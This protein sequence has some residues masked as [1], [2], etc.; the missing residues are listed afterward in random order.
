M[1]RKILNKEMNKMNKR[2]EKF[3]TNA[4]VNREFTIQMDAIPN[5]K[6]IPGDSV[7]GHKSLEV[8]NMMISEKEIGQQNENL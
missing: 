3:L 2:E 4:P 1:K 5:N 7:D 6:N 8:A